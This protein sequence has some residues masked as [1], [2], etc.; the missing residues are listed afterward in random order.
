MQPKP[1]ETKKRFPKLPKFIRTF[2]PH[3][4][5]RQVKELFVSSIIVNFA[6]AMVQIFEPIYLYQIGYPLIKIAFFYLIV[7]GLYFFL[8]P[9][10]AKFAN[11][12]GYENSMFL[13]TA[14]YVFFYISLFFIPNYPFLFYVA[15]IVCTLQKTFYWTGFHA[16]FAHNSED[17]EEGR[18]ISSV[19]VSNAIMF[20]LGPIIG[21]F[22]VNYFGFAVLFLV[23]SILFLVSNIPMLLTKEK[24][25]IRQYKYKMVF[26][27]FKKQNWKGFLACV[28]YA[29]EL[30]VMVIWPIFMFVKI[31]NYS[32]IGVLVGIAT[33]ITLTAT[34]YIGRM[35]DRRDKKK[36]LRFGSIIYSLN[37]LIRIFTKTLF[38]IFLV[39]TVSRVSK[40][41][42][43][44][45]ILS[46]F[47][48]KAKFGKK[49]NDNSIMENVVNYEVGLIIGKIL[50]CLFIIAV[51]YIF[52][53]QDSGGFI[54]SF[55]FASLASLLYMLYK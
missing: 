52:S 10:G 30:I 48:K 43:S 50:A 1:I 23:V 47:Y 18:E 26:D 17:K 20:I 2:L 9:L 21:G 12:F 36:I 32:K 51:I 35:C 16:D 37:W 6:L 54:A 31:I 45:P 13:G 14:F 11:R 38:P 8:I 29:E 25:D 33:G 44:V 46:L 15:A 7:Y 40:S 49:K 19:N 55:V 3:R 24:F 41:T 42:I 22:I 53:L 27:I 5:R 28:G 34:L 4:M 39:D